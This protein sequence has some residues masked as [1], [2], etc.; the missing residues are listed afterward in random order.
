[1]LMDCVGLNVQQAKFGKIML[2]YVL[3]VLQDMT[4]FAKDAQQDQCL[5]I[6]KQPVSVFQLTK[7]SPQIFSVAL[8]ALLTL[9]QIQPKLDANVTQDIF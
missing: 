4:L 8:I 6:E 5:M 2:V 9:H 1:V 7:F 3:M